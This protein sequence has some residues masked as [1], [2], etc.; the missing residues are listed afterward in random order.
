MVELYVI[1][2]KDIHTLYMYMYFT[3]NCT[4]CSSLGWHKYTYTYLY[5]WHEVTLHMIC[6]THTSS[7]ALV[8][9]S[10]VDISIGW[11]HSS[12]KLS[13]LRPGREV[14]REQASRISHVYGSLAKLITLSTSGSTV[15]RLPAHNF[16]HRTLRLPEHQTTGSTVKHTTAAHIL[17]RVWPEG[18]GSSVLYRW[19]G[20]RQLS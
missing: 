19:A 4:S 3:W 10:I 2:D 15:A 5:I 16:T 12:L 18:L 1:S 7:S 14:S 20:S 9:L 13:Y 6:M 17:I 8:N 11:I